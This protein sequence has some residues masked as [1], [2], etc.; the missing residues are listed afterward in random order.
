MSIRSSLSAGARKRRPTRWNFSINRPRVRASLCRPAVEPVMTTIVGL[1]GTKPRGLSKQQEEL[2]TATA[3]GIGEHIK[4][5]KG[6]P[7]REPQMRQS[8]PGWLPVEGERVEL[9]RS[10][11]IVRQGTIETVMYDRSS[12]WLAADGVDT[13]IFVH[14]NDNEVH[15]DGDRIQI[16]S[17]GSGPQ[18]PKASVRSTCQSNLP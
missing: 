18:R 17:S 12:F 4:A 14:L 15:L 6:Q 3:S 1:T 8:G 16:W 11:R 7:D 2:M 9:R 10:G 13:R 5:S